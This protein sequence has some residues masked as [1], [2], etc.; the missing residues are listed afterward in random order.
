MGTLIY[1]RLIIYIG[2]VFATNL[3][4]SPYSEVKHESTAFKLM[5]G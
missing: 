1:T 4:F 2:I 3:E 5:N